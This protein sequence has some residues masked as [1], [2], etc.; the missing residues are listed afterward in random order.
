MVLCL[1]DWQE[2]NYLE[3]VIFQAETSEQVICWFQHNAVL[4]HV[5]YG[6][7]LNIYTESGPG[8]KYIQFFVL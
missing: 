8:C 3:N 1:V 4:I 5:M 6:S 2:M 7:K